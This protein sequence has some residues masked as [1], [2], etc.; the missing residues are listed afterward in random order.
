MSLLDEIGGKGSSTCIDKDEFEE[1][2][3]S[4]ASSAGHDEITSTTSRTDHVGLYPS[5]VNQEISRKTGESLGQFEGR[6]QN[7]ETVMCLDYS[8]EAGTDRVMDDPRPLIRGISHEEIFESLDFE[9]MNP[10]NKINNAA[11]DD[12][13]T[14]RESCDYNWSCSNPADVGEW[15]NSGLNFEPLNSWEWHNGV[16][17][18]YEMWDGGLDMLS[19]FWGSSAGI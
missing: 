13:R 10:E 16:G 19:L 1:E 8:L 7:N 12:Q 5:T 3:Q 18:N 4:V 15:Y 17:K 9:L 2:T 14:I 6:I 11:N